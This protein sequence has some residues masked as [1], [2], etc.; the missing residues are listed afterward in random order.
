MVPVLL[1]VLVTLTGCALPHY[2]RGNLQPAKPD[3]E[4]CLISGC[5]QAGQV[6]TY[7][8]RHRLLHGEYRCE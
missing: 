3:P 5:R 4:D 7:R 1:L 6:C 8:E 2:E